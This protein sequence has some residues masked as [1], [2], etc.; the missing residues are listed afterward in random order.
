MSKMSEVHNELT[1]HFEDI[2]S[3]ILKKNL[4][5]EKDIA[6]FMI[7]YAIKWLTIMDAKV[8]VDAFR[9]EQEISDLSEK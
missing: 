7:D 4:C 9:S 8:T 2:A 6:A 1:G 5:S 3:E